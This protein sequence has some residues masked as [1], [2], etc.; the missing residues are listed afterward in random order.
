MTARAGQITAVLRDIWDETL[1]CAVGDTDTLHALGGTSLHA[2]QIAARIHAELGAAVPASTVFTVDFADLAAELA[3]CV[4]TTR[5]ADDDPSM[6]HGCDVAPLSTAQRRLWFAHEIAPD[7]PDYHVGFAFNLTGALEVDVLNRALDSL[8]A[9]HR[10][11]RVVITRDRQGEPLQQVLP[12][13]P[14][15]VTAEPTPPAALDAAVREE[16]RRPFDLAHGPLW[17]ARLLT[18]ADDRHVLVVTCH[19]LVTDHQTSQMLF[20]ELAGHYNALRAGAAVLEIPDRPDYLDY[21]ASEQSQRTPQQRTAAL[22]FWTDALDASGIRPFDLAPSPGPGGDTARARA[23]MRADLTTALNEL[24]LRCGASL[25]MVMLAAWQVLLWRMSGQRT[26]IVTVPVTGRTRPDRQNVAGPLLNP[27][28]FPVQIDPAMRFTDL[29]RRVRDTAWGVVEHDLPVEELIA[30]LP[31][32]HDGA[33]AALEALKFTV[34]DGDPHTALRLDGLDV[35]PLDIETGC[36]RFDLGLEVTREAHSERLTLTLTWREGR[37]SDSYAT[38]MLYRYLRLLSAVVD[39][40][41]RCVR[42]FDVVDPLERPWLLALGR[43]D[44]APAGELVPQLVAR[45]SRTTPDQPAVADELVPITYRD[46]DQLAG[47]LA[48]ALGR[49]GVGRGD[50]VAILLPPSAW[51]PAAVAGIWRLAAA[52]VPLSVD[53]PPERLRWVCANSAAVAVVKLGAHPIDEW[54]HGPQFSMDNLPDA[55]ADAA[56]LSGLDPA[57]VI[58]TS[59]TTGNPKGVVVPHNALANVAAW[60]RRRFAVEPHDQV[61]QVFANTFDPALLDT[62]SA[63]SAGAT[64]HI[65]STAQRHDADLLCRWLRDHQITIAGVPTGLAEALLDLPDLAGLPLR[66]MLVGGDRLHW[67]ASEFVPFEVVNVY[68]PTE[69]T[70][71]A[72]SATVTERTDHHPPPIGRPMDGVAAYILDERLRPVPVGVV[73]ELY[74]AGAGVALG[75]QDRPGLTAERFLPDP[76]AP[77]PGRMYRTGDLARWLSDGNIEFLGRG[78]DQVKVRGHRIELQ[79]VEVV[80]REC[81]AVQQAVAAVRDQRLIGYVV[82]AG[83]ISDLTAHMRVRL[84]SHLVPDVIVAIDD[85]PLTPNGKIDR[86][87]LPDPAAERPSESIPPRTPLERN[88]CAIWSD[89]LG[90]DEIGVRDNFFELGGH[91]LLAIKTAI[92]VRTRLGRDLSVRTMLDHP[93]IEGLV[94][95][96]ETTPIRHVDHPHTVGV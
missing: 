66:S 40:P 7:R 46:L 24:A 67:S 32:T 64:L 96:L 63:L 41:E 87:R 73:G 86:G 38:A 48:W 22:E 53:W 47:R 84:P 90:V 31:A 91:S 16:V 54:W 77:S 10:I 39:E 17:R 70:I 28:P 21:A 57:Y 27:L 30:A 62:W 9:R 76:F 74:L 68:G 81:P 44:T 60:H 43:G 15:R 56:P 75:Y 95:H 14:V 72:T 35:T 5:P 79:E 13:R 25:F 82:A 11:L 1:G 80:L 42:E 2:L 88:L 61:S 26:G 23:A 52:Y 59:G 34:E 20:R 29:V 33:G 19:H 89:L 85:L 94:Q 36:G 69:A 58:Y 6:S 8:V 4:G 51:Y 50:R 65:A 71:W 12:A 78:D 18:H 93:T 49:A 83:N 45:W 37:Y 55:V 3:R 92:A